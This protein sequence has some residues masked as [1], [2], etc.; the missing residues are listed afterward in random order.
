MI[1]K[2]GH[3]YKGLWISFEAGEGA[4]KDTQLKLLVDYLRERDFA[5]QTGREP[6]KTAFGEIM[7]TALQDPNVKGLHPITELF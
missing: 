7:R 5:V 4:G 1:A 6:G 3:L 2:R